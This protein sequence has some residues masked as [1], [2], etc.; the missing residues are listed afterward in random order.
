MNVVAATRNMIGNMYALFAIDLGVQL[1][2]FHQIAAS[3]EPL[4]V[5]MLIS[6]A[7]CKGER[8]LFESW[9]R[10]VQAAGVVDVSENGKLSFNEGWKNA[11]TDATSVEYI[12]TL[13]RCYI[14]L[15]ETYPKFCA[16]FKEGKKM[17]WQDLGRSIIEDIS[18]D[19]VRAANFFIERV[20]DAIP[21]LRLK[22]ERGAT[23]YDI[24]CA[25]GHPTMRL[26][27]AFPASRFVGIDSSAEA[28]ELAQ[29]HAREFSIGDRL[30]FRTLCATKLPKD[31]ADV[32]FFNDT[33]HEM[34]E[35]LRITAF[36]AMRGALRKDGGV[37]ISDPLAPERQADYLKESTKLPTITF[38]FEVPFGAKAL[39]R[40]E[41][42]N[43]LH[44]AGFCIVKEIESSETEISAYLKPL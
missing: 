36:K 12:A 23:V 34:N 43:M 29:A 31:V 18:I 17:A 9:A 13:P 4:S 14:A 38:F 32:I 10:A 5:D 16:L 24:G 41:M 19:G 22:L 15:A 40:S 35:D 21:G 28:I 44:E 33:L 11:L 7:Q 8:K 6:K 20:V 1:G 26:A 27:Q 2:L 25:A 3:R 42:E 30:E 37:F 39:T